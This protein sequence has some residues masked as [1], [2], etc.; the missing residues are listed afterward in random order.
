MCEELYSASAKCESK[1]GITAGF[2]QTNRE[3]RD[4]ENQV[5]NEFMVCNFIESLV[6]DSYTERG[7]STYTRNKT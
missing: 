1:N 4:Y 3:E 2:I 7:R 6:L 5:E